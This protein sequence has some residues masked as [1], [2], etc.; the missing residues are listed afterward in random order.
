V[1]RL[2]IAMALGA[3][4]GIAWQASAVAQD[5][6]PDIVPTP[7]ATPTPAPESRPATISAR[8]VEDTNGN[9]QRD[10]EDK[11]PSEQTLIQLLPWS[12]SVDRIVSLL[13]DADGSF[14]FVNVPEGDYTLY[15]WWM[16]GFVNGGSDEAPH[17]LRAV[18]RID[19]D[20]F[21]TAPSPLPATWP[22]TLGSEFNPERDRTIIGSV[23][24]FIL[25]KPKPA[26]L[27]PYPVSVGDTTAGPPPIGSVDVGL[28]LAQQPTA[29]PRTGGGPA[30]DV[31]GLL[32]WLGAAALALAVL[33]GLIIARRRARA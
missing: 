19:G 1:R 6:T 24:P 26:G 12:G 15:V 18:L 29:L 28:I 31:S 17:V 21:I 4:P 16:A 14:S 9:G 22:G 30:D 5:T 23:P 32:R 10:V 33:S 2:L 11:P 3:L 27:V 13:T 8:L 20:G 7:S 25:L